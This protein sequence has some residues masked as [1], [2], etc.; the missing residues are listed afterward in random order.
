MEQQ[1]QKIPI[2]DLSPEIDLLWDEINSA[3]QKVLRSAQFIM[4]PEVAEL[5]SEIAAF[6]GLNTPLR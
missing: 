1:H 2:L 3:I 4:G 6:L 5:E